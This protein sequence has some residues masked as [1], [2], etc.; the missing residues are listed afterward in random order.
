MHIKIIII[1]IVLIILGSLQ[2]TLNKMLLELK[3][4]KQILRS[5]YR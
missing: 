3:E 4:I 5:K 1:A 2:L